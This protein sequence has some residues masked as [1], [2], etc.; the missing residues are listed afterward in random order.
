MPK[1]SCT[2]CQTL[3]LNFLR[4]AVVEPSQPVGVV[5]LVLL[6][7]RIEQLL[8]SLAR[9]RHSVCLLVHQ[10]PPRPPNLTLENK[11]L[12]RKCLDGFDTAVPF[13]CELSSVTQA[14]EPVEF[15]QL[16]INSVEM[17]E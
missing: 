13:P 8:T 3:I 15:V 7:S 16:T 12:R 14:A 6:D 10:V 9:C 11:S 5:L 1:L 4:P 17:V 2:I